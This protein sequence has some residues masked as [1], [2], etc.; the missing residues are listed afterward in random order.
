MGVTGQYTWQATRSGSG[1]IGLNIRS[2]HSG[3]DLDPVAAM[4]SWMPEQIRLALES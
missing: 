3:L 4:I 1:S 2:L